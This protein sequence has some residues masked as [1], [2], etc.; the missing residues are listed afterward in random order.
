ME[1]GNVEDDRNT[2]STHD[3]S[4]ELQANDLLRQL[5]TARRRESTETFDRASD[6]D[7]IML[8]I[9]DTI[10]CSQPPELQ[11]NRR[12]ATKMSY[13]DLHRTWDVGL[14]YEDQHQGL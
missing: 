4:T 6:P 7:S 3:G 13:T 12:T 2:A 9:T 1:N 11:H 14:R 10:Y 8:L 5:E